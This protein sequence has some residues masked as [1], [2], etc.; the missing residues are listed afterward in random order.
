MIL[1][2]YGDKRSTR[3]N[4]PLI[5][6]IN[7]GLIILNELMVC[8]T[9][10]D[11]FCL[12]PMFQ[13]DQNFYINWREIRKVDP[14]TVACV[15]EYRSTANACL[16]D[17]AACVWNHIRS[18]NEIIMR[19]KPKL[20]PIRGVNDM[21]IADKVQNRKDFEIYHEG[22]HERSD[23]LIFYFKSWLETL[24]IKEEKYQEYKE[25]LIGVK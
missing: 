13:S 3:S 12:H 4:V 24:G 21:L 2:Y 10:K 11:A 18:T 9:T 15:I 16:S 22:K 23:E 25:L 7:E 17:Q 14:E 6:H 19:T 5:N 20:S 1:E 8:D